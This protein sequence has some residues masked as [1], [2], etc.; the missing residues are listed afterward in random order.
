[1]LKTKL[2][3]IPPMPYEY[4]TNILMHKI[5]N[6]FKIYHNKHEDTVKVYINCIFASLFFYYKFHCRRSYPILIFIPGVRSY[7]SRTS[8]LDNISR[9]FFD[10]RKRFRGVNVQ[11]KSMAPQN[12]LRCNYCK[13]KFVHTNVSKFAIVSYV[14]SVILFCN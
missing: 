13:C 8:I 2:R 4:W 9:R 1:M 10:R 12:S 7:R 5:K 11:A 14:N 3:R 6:W